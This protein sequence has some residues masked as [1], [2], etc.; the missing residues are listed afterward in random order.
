LSQ[1]EKFFQLSRK[2]CFFILNCGLAPMRSIF[3][4]SGGDG[5]AKF[6][7]TLNKTISGSPGFSAGLNFS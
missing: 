1:L 4:L 6:I 3:L 7:G 2:T 5:I